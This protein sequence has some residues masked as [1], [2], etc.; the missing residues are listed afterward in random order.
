M[1]I[2]KLTPNEREIYVYLS[3]ENIQEFDSVNPNYQPSSLNIELDWAV[4]QDEEAFTIAFKHLLSKYGLEHH[5]DNLL[6]LTLT[7]FDDIWAQIQWAH[8]DYASKKRARELAQLLLVLQ[9][10]PAVK[11]GTIAFKALT[12]DAKVND[13][14]LMEWICKT[15]LKAIAGKQYPIGQF[16]DAV[17]TILGGQ[18]P[19]NEA[20]DID[21][22]LLREVLKKRLINPK[23][24][25][26]KG[27]ADLCLVVY[28]YLQ[29]GT[30]LKAESDNNFSDAQL[31][32]LFDLLVL[33]KQINPDT[34]TTEPKDYMRTFLMNFL[35]E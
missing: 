23:N 24:T 26:R 35:K 9:E 20:N 17:H 8:E 33:L 7:R 32:F 21:D 30:Q 2:Y 31:N 28:G 34:I 3:P 12:A 14:I 25:I 5:Y 15:L 1:A 16:G 22:D 11:L 6:Y 18:Q 10:T 4:F 27:Q 13:P 19:I 29:S